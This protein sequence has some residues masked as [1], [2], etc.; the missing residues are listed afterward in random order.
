MCECG[1]VVCCCLVLCYDWGVGSVVFVCGWWAALWY[2]CV[3]LKADVAGG[4]VEESFVSFD[5]LY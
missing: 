2:S 5:V 4:S 3:G 1:E